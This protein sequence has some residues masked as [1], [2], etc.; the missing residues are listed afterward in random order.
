MRHGEGMQERDDAF[1]RNAAGR[2]IFEIDKLLKPQEEHPQ[3]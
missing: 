2:L 1:L 3:D